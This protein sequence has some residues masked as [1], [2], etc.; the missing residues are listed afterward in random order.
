MAAKVV[1]DP[2]DKC[3]DVGALIS[4]NEVN[5]I[6]DLV[7]DAVDEGAVI[8]TGG[9][10]LGGPGHFY[11]PTVLDG[12]SSDSAILSR[13]IFGPVAPLATFDDID[14]AVELANATE[15]GLIASCDES[16]SVHRDACG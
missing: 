5:K 15:S 3:S 7:Q 16:G 13:E 14:Q 1:G 11:S 10:P 4:A 8:R 6:H 12:C 9:E 2:R